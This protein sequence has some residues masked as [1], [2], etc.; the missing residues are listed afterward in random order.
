VNNT[1]NL[2]PTSHCFPVF[3]QYWSKLCFWRGSWGPVFNAV[4]WGNI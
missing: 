4:V 2:H 3:V 1:G